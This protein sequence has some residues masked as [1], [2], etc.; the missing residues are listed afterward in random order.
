MKTVLARK[1][2][3][4]VGSRGGIKTRNGLRARR[5]IATR[6]QLLR[7]GRQLFSEKGLY[8]SSIEELAER[9]GIAK[10]TV[11]L[12]FSSKVELVR[13]LV[14]E[15]LEDL[16]ARVDAAVEGQRRLSGIVGQ[17]VQAHVEYF[18]DHPDFMRILHQVRGILKFHRPEWRPL[19]TPLERFISR[20]AR[21]LTRAPTSFRDPD[22][23]RRTLAMIL[24]GAISGACSVRAALETGPRD[25]RWARLLRK[26]IEALASEL[27]TSDR[28]RVAGR[29]GTRR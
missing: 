23:Q 8:E 9:A 26:G 25:R 21:L 7:A 16:E 3:R 10:G 4:H 2:S 29:Q 5:K 24:F 28:A 11:Y 22:P 20:L 12:Y 18:A 13:V 19:R 14:E 6:T 27:A 17:I 1:T 15:G